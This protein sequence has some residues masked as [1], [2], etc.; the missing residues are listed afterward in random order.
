MESHNSDVLKEHGIKKKDLK[1]AVVFTVL[2][3]YY[4]YRIMLDIKWGTVF[5]LIVS[6]KLNAVK[7]L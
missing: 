4:Q 7:L 1:Y 5:V 2:V 3:K 6:K